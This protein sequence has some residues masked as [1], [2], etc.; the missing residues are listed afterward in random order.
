M[1]SARSIFTK[2]T[3]VRTRALVQSMYV[4]NNSFLLFPISFF[5]IGFLFFSLLPKLFLTLCIHRTPPFPRCPYLN[6]C[7]SIGV[8]FLVPLLLSGQKWMKLLHWLHILFYPLCKLSLPLM[9]KSNL[10]IFLYLE[11]KRKYI[12]DFLY[13]INNMLIISY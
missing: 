2:M 5:F 13:L 8:L 6:Y 11:G 3:P 9:L 10:V 12:Y 4:I 7:I 1:L